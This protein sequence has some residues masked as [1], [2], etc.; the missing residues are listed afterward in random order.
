LEAGE[1]SHGF[2]LIGLEDEGKKI[3]F[4]LAELLLLLFFAQVGVDADVVGAFVAAEVEDFK[5]AVVFA[6]GLE[7]ALHAD[8]ALAGGVDGEL[9]EIGGDPLAAQLFC[10]GGG[11]AG[12]AEE[13]GDEVAFL[14]RSFNKSLDKLLGFLRRIIQKL[15]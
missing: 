3:G 6:F 13:V 11:G 7:L 8:Q 2:G 12:A 10:N 15:F 1:A 5:G 14:R 9:A 4:F